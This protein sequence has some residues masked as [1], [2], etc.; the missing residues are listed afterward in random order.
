M[1]NQFSEEDIIPL[2]SII[3]ALLSQGIQDSVCSTGPA[4]CIGTIEAAPRRPNGTLYFALSRKRR[5]IVLRKEHYRRTAE[6]REAARILQRRDL[7]RYLLIVPA[8]YIPTW[9][10][11]V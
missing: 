8:D 3:E 9:E 6:F 1:T 4:I 7:L 2:S 10:G 11:E 5:Q